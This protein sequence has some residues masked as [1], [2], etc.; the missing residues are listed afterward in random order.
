MT[1]AGQIL[2]SYHL[3]AGRE[4]KVASTYWRVARITVTFAFFNLLVYLVFHRFF[5]GIFTQDEAI[6][7]TGFKIFLIALFMEPIR[8][9]NVLGGVALKTVGDGRFSVI[10][11]IIFMWGLVPVLFF[12]SSLGFGIIGLWGCLLADETIRAAI[13]LWRWKSGRWLGKTVIEKETAPA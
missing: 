12:V 7:S 6:I 8:S 4:D 11:G 5:F 2:M 3:G 1:F 10:M 9:I 13:N